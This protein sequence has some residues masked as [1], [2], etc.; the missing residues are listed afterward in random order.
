[1][2]RNT[3]TAAI[4]STNSK[5]IWAGRDGET[6]GLGHPFKSFGCTRHESIKTISHIHPQFNSLNDCNR[7]LCVYPNI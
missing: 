6:N 3:P 5:W 2:C 1:M 4:S 7:D